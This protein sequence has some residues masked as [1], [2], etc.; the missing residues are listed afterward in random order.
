MAMSLIHREPHRAES[1]DGTLTVR[2]PKL[3]AE[4]PRTVQVEVQ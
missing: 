2:I 1:K 3:K 4:K